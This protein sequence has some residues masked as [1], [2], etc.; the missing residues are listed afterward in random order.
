[1]TNHFTQT[2][3]YY[4]L[5]NEINDEELDDKCDAKTFHDEGQ[6][7]VTS[8]EDEV[9]YFGNTGGVLRRKDVE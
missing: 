7:N 9:S 3:I 1:M 5:D 2:S 6:G 8:G 4:V